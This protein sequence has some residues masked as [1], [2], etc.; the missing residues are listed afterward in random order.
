MQIRGAMAIK[1]LAMSHPDLVLL[2]YEMPI[3]DGRQVLEMIRAEAEFSDVPVIF[4]TGK[5][6]RESVMKATALKPEGYLLKSMEP[7]QIV[8]AIDEFFEKKKWT[9]SSV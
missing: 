1:Y 6:D 5:N 8:H 4:L 9:V 2:D 7:A 3:C